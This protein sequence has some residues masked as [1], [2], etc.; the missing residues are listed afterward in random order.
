MSAAPSLVIFDLGRVLI[1]LCD[2]FEHACAVAGV[3]VPTGLPALTDAE[4]ARA[5]ELAGLVDSGRIDLATYARDIAPLRR[6]RPDDV[7]KLQDIFLRG[8]FPGATELLDEL[9]AAGIKTACL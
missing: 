4:K 9:H 3:T 7:L 1:R 2:G 6:L 5:E 8:P